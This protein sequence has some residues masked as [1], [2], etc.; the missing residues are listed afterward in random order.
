MTEDEMLKLAI[1]Q[2]VK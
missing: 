2:S 1:E